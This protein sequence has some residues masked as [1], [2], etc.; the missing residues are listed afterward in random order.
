MSQDFTACLKRA[1]IVKFGP[2]K[3]LA[4]SELKT[5]ADDLRDA[6]KSFKIGMYKWATVQAYYSIA[7]ASKF[8]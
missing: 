1:K 7:Q 4:A 6:Q 3:K 2:A 8:P 5:A